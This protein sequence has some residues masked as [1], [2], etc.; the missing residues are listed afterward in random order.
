MKFRCKRSG[1]IMDF[2]FDCEDDLRFM[3]ENESYEEVKDEI[4]T[5]VEEAADAT[6]EK[7]LKKAGRPKK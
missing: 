4:E 7:V 5:K 1:N 2:T 6:E 3:R